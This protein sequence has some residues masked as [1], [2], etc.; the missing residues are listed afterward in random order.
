MQFEEFLEKVKKDVEHTLGGEYMVYS[1]DVRKN[2]D[3]IFHGIVIRHEKAKICPMIYLDSFYYD[4]E[5]G[6]NID[7]IVKEVLE[8]YWAALKYSLYCHVDLS[9][10][11]V[12]T[13]IVYRLVNREKNEEMLKECPMIPFLDLAVTFHV[14]LDETPEKEQA[15]IRVTNE[16]MEMWGLDLKKLVKLA[17]ENT[18]KCLP[19]VIYTMNDMLQKITMEEL[20][21]KEIKEILDNSG[22][23]AREKERPEEAGE[24]PGKMAMELY[25]LTNEKKLYGATSVLYRNMIKEFSQKLQTDFYILP[26]SVHEFIMIPARCRFDKAELENIVRSVNHTKLPEEDFL[27]DFIYYYCRKDERFQKL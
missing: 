15:S 25:I 11:N 27:S 16:M 21:Q 3:I 24:W 19:A 5:G 9:Y 13:Q 14:L 2:N 10:E 12:L 17:E 26:S 7:E 23:E 8:Q 18:E 6:R 4:L 22:S 20:Q 1:N